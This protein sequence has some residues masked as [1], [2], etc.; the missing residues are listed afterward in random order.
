MLRR[1]IISITGGVTLGAAFPVFAQQPANMP[2]IAILGSPEP[3]SLGWERIDAFRRG[4]AQL[5]YVEGKNILIEHRY[6]DVNLD[7]VAAN[8]AELVS[9]KVDV[10]VTMGGMDTRA[11][12]KAT[13]T[14]PIVMAQ[15]PDPVRSGFVASLGRPGGNT[16][17]L[18]SLGAELAGKRLGLLKEIV[19]KLSRVAVFGTSANPIN[20]HALQAIELAAKG[21]NVKVQYLEVTG[22]NDI[23][24]ALRAAVQGRAEALVI[25]PGPVLGRESKRIATFASIYH[26]P[27]VYDSQVYVNNG[28]LVSYAADIPDLARRAAS[29]VDKILKGAKPGDLPIEQPTKFDLALNLKTAKALGLTI[30]AS[31]MVKATKVIE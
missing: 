15:D 2:R 6:T 21:L 20:A 24:N 5:G 7:R 10:I 3:Q 26:L 31:V 30:P 11:A 1:S 29:Y 12:Q 18:S 28:G 9:L 25:L 14:I 27:A 8:A 4:L 13:N 16:T 22:S 19:P 23:E 17:G